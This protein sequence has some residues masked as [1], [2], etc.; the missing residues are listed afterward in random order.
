MVGLKMRGIGLV[1]AALSVA[2]IAAPAKAMA[3]TDI[4]PG[5]VVP[6]QPPV[7]APAP[8][9]QGKVTSGAPAASPEVASIPA[10]KAAGDKVEAALKKLSPEQL[11]H[12]DEYKQASAAFP[13]FCKDWEAKLRAREVDN[14]KHILFRLE[15][16]F[17]T[18]VYTGYSTVSACETHQSSGGFSIGKLS[19][20]EYKYQLRAN[21]VEEAMHAK[22][23]PVED[24]HTTEIFRWE[25]GT[26]FDT[27]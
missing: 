5:A 8:A 15:G 3:Q 12:S 22:A 25:K 9:L 17:Q 13:Q 6:A 2:S 18:G 1:I 27:K 4:Q 24:T 19:Y 11:L 10:N 20:E 23:A 14:L 7:A 26:W 21:S 16:G